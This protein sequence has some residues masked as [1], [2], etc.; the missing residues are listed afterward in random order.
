MYL[1]Y[2][3]TSAIVGGFYYMTISDTKTGKYYRKKRRKWKDLK[4][5][6]SSQYESPFDI[7]RIS[8][9]MLLQALYADIIEVFDNRVEKKSNKIYELTYYIEGQMFKMPLKVKRGPSNI[10][11]AT[12]EKDKC[13]LLNIKQYSTPDGKF[14]NE[15]LTPKYLGCDEI[16]IETMEDEYTFKEDQPIMF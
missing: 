4:K 2:L 9:K 6:V 3:A 15:C 13:V 14:N 11:S 12:N 8:C 5:M 16:N 10:L 7:Y 1:Y